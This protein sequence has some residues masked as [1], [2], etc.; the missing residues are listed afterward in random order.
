MR[1]LVAIA[2]LVLGAAAAS[3]ADA[4]AVRAGHGHFVA[5]YDPVGRP[6]GQVFI[7]D[8][9]PGV[10][11]RAYWLA[12]WRDRHYFPFGRD[13]FDLHRVRAHW[14]R[15]RPAKSFRRY[16]SASSVF[17]VP[18]PRYWPAPLPAPRPPIIEK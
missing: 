15:P 12:P 14:V 7:Y 2:F 11:V 18:P 17:E 16:W 4:G 9:E 1:V 10:V 13:R 6:A 3:A 8:W 5:H